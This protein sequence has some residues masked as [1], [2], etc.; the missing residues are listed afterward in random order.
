MIP[1][2][3]AP[4]G[5]VYDEG[6]REGLSQQ[7]IPS[8]GQAPAEAGMP[9]SD[10]GARAPQG[11]GSA[12]ETASGGAA[13]AAAGSGATPTTGLRFLDEEGARKILSKLKGIDSV[14]V[15]VI[16][17]HEF[18]GPEVTEFIRAAGFLV[19]YQR[20]ERIV[21]APTRR[22]TMQY[23]GRAATITVAPDQDD[24]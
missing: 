3:K 21:P 16:G 5:A 18:A 4:R 10:A 24:A 6:P 9:A 12:D 7:D 19:S 11:A 23:R 13:A 22:Y 1:S 20:I 17:A 14:T 15:R 2:G 8:E